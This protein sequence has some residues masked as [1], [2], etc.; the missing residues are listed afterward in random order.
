MWGAIVTF[1]E[2]IAQKVAEN[3]ISQRQANEIVREFEALEKKYIGAG[4]DKIAAGKAAED[5]L[6][7]KTE[8]FNFGFL[9]YVVTK[10]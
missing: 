3:K 6:N 4:Q 7:K 1:L 9:I 5:L 2:C 8:A 10:N